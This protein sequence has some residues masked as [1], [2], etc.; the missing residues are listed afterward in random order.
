[1][2]IVSADHFFM[3]NAEKKYEFNPALIGEAHK[4][5]FLNYLRGLSSGAKKVAVMVGIP[6]SG[7]SYHAERL[8]AEGYLV[9]DNTNLSAWEISP[10]MLAGESHGASVTVFRVLCEPERAFARQTHGVPL[11]GHSRMAGSF[12]R[13]DVLPWWKVVEIAN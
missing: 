9:V 4:F 12:A 3:Q 2:T 13:R 8:S 10:Y 6:G 7:K 5:C 11:A 1:M